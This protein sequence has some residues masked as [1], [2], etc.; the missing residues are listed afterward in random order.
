[1]F[2]IIVKYYISRC[3]YIIRCLMMIFKQEI[4]VHHDYMS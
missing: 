3:D 2:Y 1:M 4:S